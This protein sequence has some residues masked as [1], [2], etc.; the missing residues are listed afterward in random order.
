MTGTLSLV[1]FG[2]AFYLFICFISNVKGTK[3]ASHTVP[4]IEYPFQRMAPK[5]GA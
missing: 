2:M 5:D 1:Q 3:K 4:L